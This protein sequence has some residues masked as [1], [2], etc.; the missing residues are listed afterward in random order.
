VVDGDTL[1]VQ[2]GDQ[3]ESVRLNQIDAPERSQ[4]FGPEATACL[5]RLVAIGPISMCRDGRDKYGRTV[6]SVTA[7]G[8]NV[9]ERM[10]AEGCAWA[11]TK[12]LEANSL[13]PA[14]EQA[15]RQARRG[16]W[17]LDAMEPWLYRS[18]RAPVTFNATTNQWAV[19]IHPSNRGAVY[20]RVFDWAEHQY[21]D[22]LVSG[23][24]NQTLADGTV[25]RCY[26]N[27]FCIGYR[28]GMFLTYDGRVM[29]QVGTE[30]QLLPQAE[31]Q[32][33]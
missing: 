16:L 4:T 15:A 30:A 6:A 13:L 32:G 33:F 14:L 28:G 20:D 23:S 17:A 29:N 5:A 27:N 31:A 8:N 25:Y 26:A 9:S 11:Y 22:L 2:S 21:P 1:R 18:G 10:I 12:Y 24:A 19:A 7:Y 3:I